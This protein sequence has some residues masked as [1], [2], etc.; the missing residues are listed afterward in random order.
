M[1]YTAMPYSVNVARSEQ[2]DLTSALSGPR[3]AVAARRRRK[4]SPRA[5]G[6]PPAAFHGPLQRIVRRHDLR[7]LAKR[8]DPAPCAKRRVPQCDPAPRQR[9]L[10]MGNDAEAHVV[11]QHEPA[12]TEEVAAR[13]PRCCAT[14]P[15]GS[16][17]RVR[18]AAIHTKRKHR[19]CPTPPRA[20]Q[21]AAHQACLS[22]RAFTSGQG[23]PAVA[24]FR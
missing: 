24:S 19:Q 2:E 7:A 4:I 18:A 22:I 9:K 21:S 3:A 8:L 10:R 1:H 23:D 13:C 16:D 12:G 5:C 15:Q 11:P 20:G 14:S 6:A 17:L